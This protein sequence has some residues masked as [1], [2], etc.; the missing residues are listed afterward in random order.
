MENGANLNHRHMHKPTPAKRRTARTATHTAAL[1]DMRAH[2]LVANGGITSTDESLRHLTLKGLEAAA[3]KPS[4][5]YCARSRTWRSWPRHPGQNPAPS[6]DDERRT[7]PS[8]CLYL[9]DGRPRR[10]HCSAYGEKV[11]DA[12]LT[13]AMLVPGWDVQGRLNLVAEA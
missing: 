5:H 1:A 11:E 2:R 9:W 13:E 8:A 4:L 12:D 7:G 3:T 10:H 6:R